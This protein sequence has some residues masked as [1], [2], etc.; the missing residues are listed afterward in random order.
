MIWR[1]QIPTKC[2]L[3]VDTKYIYKRYLHNSHLESQPNII[4]TVLMHLLRISLFIKFKCSEAQRWRMGRKS[5]FNHKLVHIWHHAALQ[6]FTLHCLALFCSAS[7]FILHIG[8]HIAMFGTLHNCTLHCSALSCPASPWADCPLARCPQGRRV[9]GHLRRLDLSRQVC[10]DAGKGGEIELSEILPLD[11]SV[12]GSLPQYMKPG[13]M[14]LGLRKS[15][16]GLCLLGCDLYG[17]L[18][19]LLRASNEV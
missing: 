7:Q 10:P 8:V 15:T 5:P 14:S 4:S 16:L 3:C 2:Y 19:V 12:L 1:I 17:N 18:S 9:P 6:Q 11:L 13:G